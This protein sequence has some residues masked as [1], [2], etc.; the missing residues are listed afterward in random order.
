MSIEAKIAAMAVG[1][2]LDDDRV[3][4]TAPGRFQLGQQVLVVDRRD[5][6][7]DRAAMGRDQRRRDAVRLVIEAEPVTPDTIQH[8]HSVRRV[9]Q[10]A[11]QEAQ[12]VAAVF[13]KEFPLVAGVAVGQAADTAATP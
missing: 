4:E 6:G 5:L 10:P 7:L 12:G 11:G 9:L 8:I 3:Q 1:D 13:A 2:V